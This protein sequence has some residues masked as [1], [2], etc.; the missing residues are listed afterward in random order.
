MITPE[1]F[2]RRLLKIAGGW[3]GLSEKDA[4]NADIDYLINAYEGKTEMLKSVFGASE[5]E[6][7]EEPLRP[8]MLRPAQ[9][10]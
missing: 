5:N 8:G 2:D 4:L 3:L 7:K 1:E 9:F 6:E 10:D